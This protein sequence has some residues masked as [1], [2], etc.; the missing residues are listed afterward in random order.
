MEVSF[1]GVHNFVKPK[2]PSVPNLLHFSNLWN[3]LDV[4]PYYSPVHYILK[5]NEKV[6]K[7]TLIKIFKVRYQFTS[8]GLVWVWKSKLWFCVLFINFLEI[9][10]LNVIFGCMDNL[11]HKLT[12][13][14][15]RKKTSRYTS[16]LTG[17]NPD[18]SEVRQA[19]AKASTHQQLLPA[20]A[21]FFPYSKSKFDKKKHF[22]SIDW[23]MPTFPL[24]SLPSHSCRT[25]EKRTIISSAASQLYKPF[26]F[27]LKKLEANDKTVLTFRYTFRLLFF[28]TKPLKLPL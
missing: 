14:K 25:T 2:V 22:Y 15:K 6:L 24:F 16:Y 9:K 28:C 19:K 12:N 20:K 3:S 17:C 23:K 4:P 27:L 8:S 18:L 10:Q 26:F 21:N 5:N 13:G 1:Y 11:S 7:L